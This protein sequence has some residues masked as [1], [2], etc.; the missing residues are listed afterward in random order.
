LD[1]SISGLADSKKLTAKKRQLLSQIINEKAK[2]TGLGWVWPAEIDELGLSR[3]TSLA[4]SRALDEMD[5]DYDEIILDGKLNYLPDN[6]KCRPQ[7]GADNAV[8]SVS[9]ASIIAKVARDEYMRKLS[10]DFPRYGFEKHV[11]YGT[12][13]HLKCLRRY[14]PC[15]AHRFS[16]KPVMSLV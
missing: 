8:P 15:R 5:K 7:V 12:K 14:G 10:A 2:C 16:Y 6:P 13:L 1:Q 11:G 3:S 9:A 4:I